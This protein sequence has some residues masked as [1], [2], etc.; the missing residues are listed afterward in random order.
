MTQQDPREILS[1]ILEIIDYPNDK[2]AFIN[3]FIITCKKQAVLDLISSLDPQKQDQL[4]DALSTPSTEIEIT[5]IFQLFF[6]DQDYQDAL[7]NAS[8]NT[9][10][11]LLEMILPDLNPKQRAEL[12]EL[13]SSLLPPP[14]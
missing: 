9:L 7:T 8:E 2:D 14:N 5:Q 3:Q 4:K 1:K 13:L 6:S 10:K 12:K 11:K